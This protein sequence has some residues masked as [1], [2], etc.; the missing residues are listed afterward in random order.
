MPLFVKGTFVSVAVVLG[1]AQVNDENACLLQADKAM[2]KAPAL[3]QQQVAAKHDFSFSSDT[4]EALSS[5]AHAFADIR[6][7]KRAAAQARMPELLESWVDSGQAATTILSLADI[8]HMAAG[9]T[10]EAYGSELDAIAAVAPSRFI[11]KEGNVLMA[12]SV[13][14]TFQSLGLTIWSEPLTV[15]GTRLETWVP[16]G[17]P[18]TAGIVGRLEGTDLAHEAI[19]VGAHFDS[20]NWENTD[21]DAP[22]VDDNGS[23]MALVLQVA[24]AF[25][26]THGRPR[27]SVLFVGFNAEE[28]GLYGSKEIARLAKTGKYGNLKSVIIA[29]EVA[30]PGKGVPS[31]ERQAIF[32]TVGM[33]NGTASMLDT[34]GRTVKKGDGVDGFKVNNHGFAS[35]HISFLHNKIPTVLLIEGDNVKHADDWGHSA[36]DTFD[37]VDKAFGASMSRLAVRVA[38]TLASPSQI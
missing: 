36:R 27:R 22:G 6:E 37:H 35:D 18:R 28:E 4:R 1:A 7:A 20:V 38:A 30:W 9:I 11:S 14:S 17:A 24:R 33:I 10:T 5:A 15:T 2:R 32:E 19:L 8:D 26:G 29:D 34:F 13:K 16:E 12:E 3:L 25:T 31:H 21:A 23:G